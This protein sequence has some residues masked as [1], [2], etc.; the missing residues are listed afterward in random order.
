[1]YNNTKKP[2]LQFRSHLNP[3][4]LNCLGFECSWKR[5]YSWIYCYK[6]RR[7]LKAPPLN[8]LDLH[9]WIRNSINSDFRM[10][11]LRYL[12]SS[13]L[14]G[15]L[16]SVILCLFPFENQS[17]L[18]K[19]FLW[20]LFFDH[21]LWSIFQSSLNTLTNTLINTLVKN[22]EESWVKLNGTPMKWVFMTAGTLKIY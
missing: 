4:H 6:E 12:N 22:Y 9:V 5:L 20:W 14:L 17:L 21:H 7:M 1:M 8:S 15:A 13:I 11:W 19:L 10:N 3:W 16:S 18:N 2:G